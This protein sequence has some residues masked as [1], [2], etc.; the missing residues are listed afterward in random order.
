MMMKAKGMGGKGSPYAKP[1]AAGAMKA[2]GGG[3]KGKG[4]G[5]GGG[6]GSKA[7]KWCE[8]GECW[9]CPG[10]KKGGGKGGGNRKPTPESVLEGV[11]EASPE[12]V[13]NFLTSHTVDERASNMLKELD[14]RLQAIVMA[15]GSMEE[16]T[17]P[18]AMLMHRIKSVSH[19]KEGDWICK[20][21]FTHEF[22]KNEACRQCGSPKP[23]A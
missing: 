4:G 19:M 9:G 13:E 21:C 17:N 7:C 12:E 20:S 14:P 8:L 11:P 1:G 23:E 16:A 2:M 6:G 22:G 3:M 15:R 5:G 18:S 10:N